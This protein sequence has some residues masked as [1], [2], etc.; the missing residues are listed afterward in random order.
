[1]FWSGWAAG[2]NNPSDTGA[3]GRGGGL[4][5]LNNWAGGFIRSQAWLLRNVA[6]GAALTPDGWPEKEY[7]R[8]ILDNT[9]AVEEGYNSL[10]TADGATYYDPA[11][12]CVAPCKTVPWRFG[13]DIIRP[14]NWNGS[15]TRPYLGNP[16]HFLPKN[17]G[18]GANV[19]G[20]QSNDTTKTYA[21]STPWMEA[22]EA[23][24]LGIAHDLGF[25]EVRSMQNMI[26]GP[27]I[28]MIKDPSLNPFTIQTY[29]WPVGRLASTRY[30]IIAATKLNSTTIQY[31]TAAPHGFA[32]GY[33]VA[34]C[35]AQAPSSWTAANY[36][37]LP[38]AVIDSTNFTISR[39]INSPVTG[40]YPGGMYAARGA[41]AVADPIGD[42]GYFQTWADWWDAFH[43]DEKLDANFRTSNIQG[44]DGGYAVIS[45]AHLAT[46]AQFGITSGP[47]SAKSAY[48]WMRANVGYT[49]WSYSNNPTCT[50][51]APYCQNPLWMIV[52]RPAIDNVQVIPTSS[53]VIFRFVAPTGDAAKVRLSTTAPDSTLDDGDVAAE[54]KNRV[55][56]A[57]LPA[58]PGTTYYYRITA[59]ALGGT[60][61]ESGTVTT[62]ADGGAFTQKLKLSPPPGLA[63]SDVVVE[64]GS[65]NSYGNTLPAISCSG[66]CEASIPANRNASIHLRWT[67]RNS[68]AAGLATGTLL[69]RVE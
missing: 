25:S 58:S 46:A 9:V 65:T 54:C 61:R 66:G 63:V 23:I 37:P 39:S 41:S 69:Q 52:P 48:A 45:A 31:T 43:P 51:T 4:G 19:Q 1:M 42:G 38:I 21:I 29:Q 10:T 47:Y 14:K 15:T 18:S 44:R 56:A 68:Q 11:P 28:R 33:E 64:Y 62:P 8:K 36:Y 67:Y 60:A 55:C 3:S 5:Y 32:T 50:V 57:E 7:F 34:I 12:D 53:A 49:G 2:V 6:Q 26:S 30:Q 40:P 16:L 35:C 24:S 20:G 59:G 17:T 13:Q 27:A 22:Y